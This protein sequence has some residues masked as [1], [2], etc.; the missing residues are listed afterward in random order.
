MHFPAY[1]GL[2]Y[3]DEVP[4]N[5]YAVDRHTGV[6][7]PRKH[8]CYIAEIVRDDT[9]VRPSFLVKDKQGHDSRVAFH[10]DRN[11]VT[12]RLS[13]DPIEPLCFNNVP[14][15]VGNTICIMY[16]NQ[17]GFMDGTCGIRVE[18]RD[19]VSVGQERS[20]PILLI[21]VSKNRYCPAVSKSFLPSMTG[22]R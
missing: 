18:E 21:R 19:C 17:H 1:R 12:F 6:Y 5:Y 13:T 3:D 7:K 20:N 15:K 10:L 11:I 8:W 2:P 16:A 14:C 22:L 4:A 9:I